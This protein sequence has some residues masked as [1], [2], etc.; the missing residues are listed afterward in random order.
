[1][2]RVIVN[3]FSPWLGVFSFVLVVAGGVEDEFADEGAVGGADAD[4]Q[5]GDGDLDRCFAPAGADAD[6]VSPD[7]LSDTKPDIERAPA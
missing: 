2:S 7:T 1:M 3:T 4:V 6:V 5:V